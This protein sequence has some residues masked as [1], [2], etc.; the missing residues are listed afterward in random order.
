M[1]LGRA[2]GGNDRA[3]DLVDLQ[4]LDQEEDVDL[5]A[6]GVTARRL[7]ASRRAHEWPP[8]VVA[9]Q[10]W[11]TLYAEAAEGLGVLPNVVAAV[12]W[13]NDLISRIP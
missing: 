7:F 1:Y 9:H 6:I 10:G 3:H 13:A 11:E 12:E 8:T 4:I 5:A 2:P